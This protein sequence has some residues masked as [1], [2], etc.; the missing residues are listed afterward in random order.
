MHL[1]LF[2]QSEAHLLAVT[3]LL[4]KA[5]H[6]CVGGL[7]LAIKGPSETEIKCKDN[8]D[9]TCTVTYLPTAP[10]EYNIT[11]KFADKNISGSPFVAKVTG[12]VEK[13]V[14]IYRQ[15]FTDTCISDDYFVT[16]K[17]IL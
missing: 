11:V 3:S 2:F 5:T 8:E 10:G 16:N 6:C 7:A 17:G 14:F 13:N 1:K 4:T 15:C 12:N 9:G